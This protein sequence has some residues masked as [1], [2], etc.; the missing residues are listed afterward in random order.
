MTKVVNVLSPETP[1][2]GKA[3]GL[4]LSEGNIISAVRGEAR[5]FPRGLRQCYDVKGKQRE[6]GR[7]LSVCLMAE[8]EIGDKLEKRESGVA[9]RVV[10]FLHSS[11]EASNDRG[12]KGG[13]FMC[14][15]MEKQGQPL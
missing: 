7:T 4:H 12:A 9:G 14:N 8:T 13:M 10:G 5:L 6:L 11:V 1:H 3:D 2:C 15:V